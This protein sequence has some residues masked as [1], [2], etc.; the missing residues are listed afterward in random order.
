MA[1]PEICKPG[2]GGLIFPLG[3]EAEQHWNNGVRLCL[4]LV[5]LLYSFV[6][7]G[8]V[9]DMFMSSIESITA[10][11]QVVKSR[12]TGRYVTFK[13]WNDTVANLTLLA[14]GSSAPEILLSLVEIILNN[15]N[16]G[17]LGP[18]TIVGSAAFNLFIIISICMYVIPS[19]EIRLI[20]EYTVFV[21]TAVF[22]LVAYAWLVFIVQLSSPDV[23]ELWE[24]VVT[25]ALFPVLVFISY[26]ADIGYLKLGG[27]KLNPS[28]P[29]PIPDARR[30]QN[31]KV[32]AVIPDQ[33]MDLKGRPIVSTA[34]VLSF[35]SDTLKVI[36][37]LEERTVHVPV[38]RMNGA[39]GIVTC[40]YRMEKLTAIPGY[41]YKEDEGTLHFAPGVVTA[42]IPITVLPKGLGKGSDRFQLLLEDV[43]GGALFN[44]HD[45]GGWKRCVLTVTIINANDDKSK[46]SVS[47]RTMNIL[48]RTVNMESIRLG[49][50]NWYE[51]IMEAVSVSDDTDEEPSMFARATHLAALPWKILYALLIPPPAYLGG[52][53]CF[54][55]ALVHIGVLT[56]VIIDIAELFGCVAGIENS[57]TAITLVALGTSLPDTFVSKTAALQDEWADS[58]IVNVTGSNSV[59]V[60]LG[61]GV[62]WTIAAL[63][64]GAA[65]ATPDWTAKYGDAFGATCPDGCFVVVSGDLAFSVIV[66]A[67]AALV[68][69]GLIRARRVALGGELGGPYIAKV[70]SSLTMVLLWVYYI[71]LSVWKT[72]SK[73]GDVGQQVTFVVSGLAMIAILVL[74]IGLGFRCAQSSQRPKVAL[75]GIDIEDRGVPGAPGKAGDSDAHK[76]PPLPP[77]NSVPPLHV[78]ANGHIN[79]CRLGNHMPAGH[80]YPSL[81]GVTTDP[82]LGG[83]AHA[84]VTR[85]L[86]FS[87]LDRFGSGAAGMYGG[88]YAAESM[89]AGSLTG[90]I[91]GYNFNQNPRWLGSGAAPG[92]EFYGHDAAYA[93]RYGVQWPSMAAQVGAQHVHNVQE[94]IGATGSDTFYRSPRH[95][96]LCY[97]GGAFPRDLQYGGNTS[98]RDLYYDNSVAQRDLDLR[99]VDIALAEDPSMM[100]NRASNVVAPG[101]SSPREEEL[102]TFRLHMFFDESVKQLDAEILCHGTEPSIGATKPDGE[103]MRRGLEPGDLLV[104][105]NGVSTSGVDRRDVMRLLRVRPLLLKVY[106]VFKVSGTQPAHI[107]L[108]LAIRGQIWEKDID[109]VLSAQSAV[110]ATVQQGSAAWIAGIL[111]GDVICAVNGC[112]FLALDQLWALLRQQPL[113]VKV[114]RWALGSGHAALAT[115]VLAGVGGGAAHA[116]S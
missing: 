16:S 38:F 68:A 101:G 93:G 24:G 111:P 89:Q 67:V 100:A 14:L 95:G 104:E 30:A 112:G 78:D 53:V 81:A 4:Y 70:V 50:M 48:D 43:T 8:I 77:P 36:G 76:K 90:P 44:P 7:V 63:Y 105:C 47:L 28:A 71:T 10:K 79:D 108:D 65:G 66:F 74:L 72:M 32:V 69:L 88:L 22:S 23:V 51:Q 57:I 49:S 116:M 80:V 2:G 6:G 9:S 61:I 83:Y 96:D 1:E 85:P 5:L 42:M 41:D 98:P 26:L 91:G 59:N 39:D 102:A 92:Y 87:S 73:S 40:R 3:G 31:E 11:K 19:P 107:E 35:G 115:A 64:W 46:R 13:V 34:G 21:I 58:S 54:V 114:R 82:Y 109:I 12:E 56:A 75:P 55:M 106:R 86:G 27:R 29:I 52:W 45:D 37:G 97:E 18:S 110:V 94:H 25:L 15:F 20:K 60:F 62:P 113:A 103:A 99:H 17:E 33:L 84:G